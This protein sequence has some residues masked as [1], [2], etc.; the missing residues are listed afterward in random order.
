M[1]LALPD[2]LGG[3]P[4]RD[5]ALLGFLQCDQPVAVSLCHE[6]CSW[7]HLS[8]LTPSIG[9]FYLAQLGHSHLAPTTGQAPL[10]GSRVAVYTDRNRKEEQH[11]PTDSTPGIF[12]PVSRG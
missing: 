5:Q 4:L 2:F 10:P 12:E 3:L 1:R 7:I 8:S 11:E 9:H 6:K